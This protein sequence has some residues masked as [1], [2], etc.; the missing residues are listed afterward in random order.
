M[1]NYL[2]S[3]KNIDPEDESSSESESETSEIKG[4][5]GSELNLD[6]ITG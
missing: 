6:E 1:D 3:L 5:I 4:T 2:S